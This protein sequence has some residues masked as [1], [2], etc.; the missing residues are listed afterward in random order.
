MPTP[1]TI[2]SAAATT[3][4]TNVKLNEWLTTSSPTWL[5][6]YNTAATPV[7]L[8][9]NYLTDSFGNKTKHL[10][11]P[12]TFLGGSGSSRWLQLIADNDSG[13]TPNHVNFTI[14]NGEGLWLFTSTGTQLDGVA[15]TAQ[16]GGASQGRLADGSATIVALLPTPGA[17]NQ[18]ASTDTDGDGIPD[19]WELANGMNPNSAADATLD[20]DGDGQSNKAEYLAGTNP[21][22]PGSKLA[23]SVAKTVTPGQY[24]I[25]FT[26]IAGKSYTVR[27][28]DDLLAATWT[29]LQ[30]V[31][32]PAS[33]TVTTINDTP[34]VPKRFYQ[35]VTPQQ[36]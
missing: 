10:I 30:Q 15:V 22:L 28:K 14:E 5:E 23:A 1:T 18:S 4:V 7:L 9:G 31:S 35:V 26:A 16:S 27:Y 25:T 8:S 32:A 2:N 6:L 17:A 13:A 34:S 21:Q 19:L 3:A 33:D 11:P 36:P 12:L 24:A 20:S 29:T